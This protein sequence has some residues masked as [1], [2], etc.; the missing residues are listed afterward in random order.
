MYIGAKMIKT[1]IKTSY[2][3]VEV[4]VIKTM[5]MPALCFSIIQIDELYLRKRWNGD[6][7]LTLF[8][9]IRH[10]LWKYSVENSARLEWLVF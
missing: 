9:R 4:C 7:S 6:G 5:K 8:H 3:S 1:W 10:F 2:I